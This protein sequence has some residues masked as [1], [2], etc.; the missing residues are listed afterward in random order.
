MD[1][2]Q[3]WMI[4]NKMD[5]TLGWNAMWGWVDIGGDSESEIQFFTQDEAAVSDLP[6]EGEWVAI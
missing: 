5:W 4:R 2:P 6:D 3:Y 1:A